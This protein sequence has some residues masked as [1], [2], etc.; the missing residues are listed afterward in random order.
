MSAAKQIQ[1]GP[2]ASKLR[3]SVPGMTCDHCVRA[4]GDEVSAV[5]G[6]D[7]VDVDL[8]TK[9]VVVTGTEIDREAVWQAVAEAG[10]EAVP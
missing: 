6:V 1:V 10:Y 4:V 5:A 7:H 9:T 2:I 3:F 8:T